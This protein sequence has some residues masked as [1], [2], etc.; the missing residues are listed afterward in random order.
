MDRRETQGDHYFGDSGTGPKDCG[1]AEVKACLGTF[2]VI[3]TAGQDERGRAHV[4]RP[5]RPVGRRGILDDRE[6]FGRDRTEG[7]QER[8]AARHRSRGQAENDVLI[9][10]ELN[11]DLGR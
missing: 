8:R 9:D 1:L 5:S 7:R 11:S 6:R 10:G 2:H 3:R 4:P